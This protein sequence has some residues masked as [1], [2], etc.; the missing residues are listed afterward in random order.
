MYGL[1]SAIVAHVRPTLHYC[2]PCITHTTLLWPIYDPH[3]TTATY[4]L[5]DPNM[6]AKRKSLSSYATTPPHFGCISTWPPKDVY[7]IKTHSHRPHRMVPRDVLRCHFLH[8][9]HREF[10]RNIWNSGDNQVVNMSFKFFTLSVDIAVILSVWLNT[11]V[12][13]QEGAGRVDR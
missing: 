5:Y 13:G 10:Q 1:H 12:W 9:H 7:F 6:A 3:S 4:V 11:I 2:G 8:R